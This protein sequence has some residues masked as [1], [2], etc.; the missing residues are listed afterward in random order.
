MEKGT[1][2][3]KS[4]ETYFSEALPEK[5]TESKLWFDSYDNVFL[6]DKLTL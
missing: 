5:R 4:Q 3:D 2:G 6:I 1:G